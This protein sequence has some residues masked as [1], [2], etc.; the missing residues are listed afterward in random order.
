MVFKGRLQLRHAPP[1]ANPWQKTYDKGRLFVT[2][3]SLACLPACLPAGRKCKRPLKEC[4]TVVL[5]CLDKH[6]IS[7]F[8]ADDKALMRQN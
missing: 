8:M 2:A 3:D 5:Y 1:V 4:H 7:L 6:A